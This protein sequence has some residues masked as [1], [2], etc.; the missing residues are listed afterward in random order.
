MIKQNDSCDDDDLP[1]GPRSAKR[2]HRQLLLNKSLNSSKEVV[3]VPAQKDATAHVAALKPRSNGGSV[4]HADEAM[5]SFGHHSEIV[6][7]SVVMQI[8]CFCDFNRL[9][10]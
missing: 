9:L 1:P 5:V 8:D 2:R 3:N 10:H 6:V 4:Q 7:C